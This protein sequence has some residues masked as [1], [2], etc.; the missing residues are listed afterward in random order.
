MR[1][2]ATRS[3]A[4]SARAPTSRCP[5]G[6]STTSTCR[7]PTPARRPATSSASSPCRAG[8]SR[9]RCATR[10]PSPAASSPS[11]RSRSRRGPTVVPTLT[12]AGSSLTGGFFT[13]PVTGISYTCVVDGTAVSFIDSNNAMYPYPAPGTADVLVAP[14]VVAT[15]VTV[16]VDDQA[17]P[18]IFPVLNN[19]FIAG[20][21]TY[22]VNVPIAYANAAGP[23]FPMVNGRFVVPRAGPQ[24]S[25]AYTVRGGNVI[26]GWRRLRRRRVLC[27]RQCR[28]HRQRG[29]R[30]QGDEP[31]DPVR[32]AARADADRR[33]GHVYPRR[34]AGDKQG[35]SPPAWSTTPEPTSS[36]RSSTGRR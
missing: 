7:S 1:A 25:L 4:T 15:G 24:S 36:P 18:G 2:T 8:S 14:V 31:G 12:A 3:S 33:R 26:K 34:H 10:S 35:L 19:Q 16:A 21:V 22:A 23:Y 9:S 29:Q 20:S 13:D 5:A 32:C 27:R 11:T 30:R 17:M 28:L 6:R